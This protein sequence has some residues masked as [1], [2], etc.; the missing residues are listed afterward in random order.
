MIYYMK[1]SICLYFIEGE[2]DECIIK[3]EY[4]RMFFDFMRI[5]VI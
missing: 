2:K 4:I 3:I 1:N 5:I